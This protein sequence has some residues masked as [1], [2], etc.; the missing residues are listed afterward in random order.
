MEI[1]LHTKTN[2]AGSI[3]PA[4]YHHYSDTMNDANNAHKLRM[5]SHQDLW[6]QTDHMESI[7]LLYYYAP[8]DI[9]SYI[10]THCDRFSWIA[11]TYYRSPLILYK[12]YVQLGLI[13]P[14]VYR[15]S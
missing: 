1:P 10:V 8:D 9:G 6:C 15:T 4:E 5:A 2:T 13:K 7:N 11:S 12:T 3:E 14:M